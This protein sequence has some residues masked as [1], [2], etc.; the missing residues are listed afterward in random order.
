MSGF[1]SVPECY[2]GNSTDEEDRRD[3]LRRL[4]LSSDSQDHI[5]AEEEA[6]DL[7]LGDVIGLG[8]VTDDVMVT[9]ATPGSFP[10]NKEMIVSEDCQD[11]PP[12][13]SAPLLGD[14]HG[15]TGNHLQQSHRGESLS[16]ADYCESDELVDL[17]PVKE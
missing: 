12:N 3:Q 4:T 15:D 8:D 14:Y 1:W 17:L 2:H 9:M 16:P 6:T 13:C 10:S 11:D 7:L 5:P